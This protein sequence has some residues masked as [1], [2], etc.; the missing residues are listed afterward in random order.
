MNPSSVHLVRLKGYFSIC[1]DN[2]YWYSKV[3]ADVLQEEDRE[4]KIKRQIEN[5]FHKIDGLS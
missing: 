4:A 5:F 2:V 1:E 3:I